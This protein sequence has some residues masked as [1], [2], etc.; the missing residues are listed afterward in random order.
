M[1]NSCVSNEG[2]TIRLL[3][4]AA[5]P[6]SAASHDTTSRRAAPPSRHLDRSRSNKREVR[7]GKKG[8]TILVT[9]GSPLLRK[10][11]SLK[12]W[13]FGFICT[14]V[15]PHF[16]CLTFLRKYRY[17]SDIMTTLI[18]TIETA[19]TVFKRFSNRALSICT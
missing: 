4:R 5:S 8:G 7:A 6:I 18:Y 10:F 17:L 19:Q 9:Y 12:H 15:S 14:K 1:L 16:C 2:L 11:Y 3:S 13:W